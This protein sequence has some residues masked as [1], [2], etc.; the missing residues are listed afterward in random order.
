[1]RRRFAIVVHIE[2]ASKGTFSSIYEA[3]RY[4]RNLFVTRAIGTLEQV[5]GRGHTTGYMSVCRR[6]L[7]RL[8]SAR[9]LDI[10]GKGD[11]PGD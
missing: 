6:L 9:A 3:C 5:L 2:S 1:M 4:T 8:E 7:L 10:D 11:V